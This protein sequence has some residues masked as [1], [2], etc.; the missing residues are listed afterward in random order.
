MT[1]PRATRR[2]I[3]DFQSQRSPLTTPERVLGKR[4]DYQ[5]RHI[6]SLNPL[7]VPSI[8]S[9]SVVMGI[10][11]L[12]LTA[13]TVIFS[14]R[15]WWIAFI[16]PSSR[17]SAAQPLVLNPVPRQGSPVRRAIAWPSSCLE[18]EHT[19]AISHSVLSGSAFRAFS[20]ASSPPG[21]ATGRRLYQVVDLVHDAQG[22][23]LKADQRRYC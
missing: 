9:Q 6:S 16:R 5:P 23:P 2:I 22:P 17:P 13:A 21:C 19:W 8:L 11:Y 15:S 18:K 10:L 1:L 4:G 7:P 20:H 3:Q 14:A 12:Q